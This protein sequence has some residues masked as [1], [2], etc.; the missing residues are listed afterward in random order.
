MIT[1]AT[2]TSEPPYSTYPSGW[3][4]RISPTIRR[5]ANGRC[6]RCGMPCDQLSVHHRGVP[7]A[8]G[9]PGD[10]RDKHD[11]RRENL[12]ALC[13][14]CHDEL[15]HL[16]AVKRARKIRQA[17]RTAK[18]AAHQALGI[19]TGLV[20]CAPVFAILHRENT[21]AKRATLPIAYRSSETRTATTREGDR[22]AW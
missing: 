16:R 22:H 12:Q 21:Q 13:F 14:A 3:K 1:H 6:E 5:L 7:F 20:P 2:K 19:G 10:K 18:Y 8:N 9:R 15:D 17:K 11:I 4:R